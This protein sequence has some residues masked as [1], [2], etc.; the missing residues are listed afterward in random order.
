MERTSKLG[1]VFLC[2]FALPFA[3]FGLFALF[4]GMRQTL[5][6]SG[7]SHSWL[8]LPFGLVFCG[9][10]FG[11]IYAVIFGGRLLKKQQRAQAEHPSEP[12]LWREDWVQGRIQGSMRSGM[13]GAW[14]FAGLWNT[15]SL[16]MLIFIPQQAARKPIAYVGL[17]F[18]LIGV[19]LLVRAIRWTIAYRTFGR[20]YFEITP[21]P[22]VIGGELKGMIQ[23]R[24]PQAPDHG[25]QLRLSCINRVTSGSGDNRST[26]EHI[27]WR[28]E[29]SV[30][31]G[32][33]Y[34]GP[35]GTSIP[36]NFRIPW[37]AQPT[38][39]RSPGDVIVWQLEA[40]A[41]VPGVDYRDVFEV[42]VFRTAQTPTAPDPDNSIDATPQTSRPSALTVVIT[43]TAEG[44]EF[45]FP[46]GRN[47]GFA[48]GTSVFLLIFG[49]ATYF[50]A[51]S[52][53]PV[54][55]PI[56]FGF[57]T[58][59]LLYICAQM[60]LGT[61]RV[62]IGK[63]ELLLQAGFLGVGRLRRFAFAEIASISSAI[64][65][66]QGGSTGTPYYDIELTLSNGKKITLGRTIP[67]H[68][69]V[70]WLV[71]KM[72]RLIGLGSKAMV[73]GK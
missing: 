55:F 34:P 43:E 3:A 60:W 4:T 47:K 46:A 15:I 58:F 9:I 6:G 30:A 68:Q 63:G 50:L 13:I 33:M 14:I 2:L 66:Q 16:P 36:V 28:A 24:I 52:R 10:G 61:T 26:W 65:S 44:I 18:P 23:A 19:L 70:A 54:F 51:G 53:A 22:G 64:R 67:N 42:P 12:W 29:A 8:F 21:V 17:L 56:V 72:K 59:L 45:Y 48:S 39:T 27:R 5:D 32:Q 38:E 57:F 35:T 69:E 71:E 20:T 73:A 25:I 49:A 62:G 11:L 37:N 41:D 1:T 7:S 31:P 40:R